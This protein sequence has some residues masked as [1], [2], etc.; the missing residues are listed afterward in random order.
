MKPVPV[1]EFAAVVSALSAELML[2]VGVIALV[3]MSL[4]YTREEQRNQA[5]WAAAAFIVAA[6]FALYMF[7]ARSFIEH[8]AAPGFVSL[9]IGNR[10]LVIDRLAIFFKFLF[11][12]IGL[13]S[14]I[15][16]HRSREIMQDHLLEFYALILAVIFGMMFMATSVDFLMIYLSIEMV[17]ILS[18]ILAGFVRGSLRSSEASLKYLLY[19]AMSSGIMIYGM[20]LIYGFSGTTNIMEIAYKFQSADFSNNVLMMM[21]LLFVFAGIGYKIAAVPF[22]FWCPDVYQGAPLPVT[23]FFSVG[24]KAAGFALAMRFFV[25]GFSGPSELNLAGHPGMQILG[26]IDW[27]TPMFVLAIAT[28]TVGNLSALRQNNAKRLLAY[29]SIAHAGYLMMA[30][31]ALTP[32]AMASIPF[33]LAIYAVMNLGAFFVVQ[34]IVEQRGSDE[35]E[36]FRG[37]FKDAPWLGV[38][39]CVFMFSLTGLPPLAGFAGKAYLFGAVLEQANS[40]GESRLWL[41]LVIGVLNSAISLFYYVRV[42]RAMMVGS[43]DTADEAEPAK[44]LPAL[45]VSAM[46]MAV[47]MIFM[48]PTIVMGVSFG[49]LIEAAEWAFS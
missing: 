11:L 26:H 10:M 30:L 32:R 7:T 37:S 24:P 6:G 42:I 8:D 47:L 43:F 36:A 49:W 1:T 46:T 17:S 19:G 44:P 39:M 23:A 34:V 18:Y 3:L 21:A 14:I 16:A 9:G 45:S 25:S 40:A 33:Y 4:K 15:I 35:L 29:S 5:S 13:L 28:M 38:A 48:I 12:G 2:A 31:V 27:R 41:L 20:S 22:H